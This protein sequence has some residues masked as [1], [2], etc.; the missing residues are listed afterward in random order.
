MGDVSTRLTREQRQLAELLLRQRGL[1]P[2]RLPMS[3]RA[4]PGRAPL[5]TTQQRLWTSG[6]AVRGTAYGN[7]PMAVRIRGSLDIDSLDRALSLIVARHEILRTTYPLED[8]QPI[9]RIGPELPV[10]AAVEDLRA[11][12]SSDRERRFASRVQE[13]ARR[14][15]DPGRETL[16]RAM[17]F[18]L[19]AADWGLLLVSHHLSTDGWGARLLLDELTSAYRAFTDGRRPDLPGLAVQYGDYAAWEAEQVRSGTFESQRLHWLTRLAGAPRQLALPFDRPPAGSVETDAIDISLPDSVVEEVRKLSRLRGVTPYVMLLAGLE[20]MLHQCTGQDDIVIG[21]ILSRRMRS[22]T[23]PL[24][25]NFG[26][27]LLLR[28][29]L[30]G[31]P[32]LMEVVD[33]AAATMRDALAH[34]DVPLE[35]VAQS[36]PIPAFHMMFILRD[37][38]LEERLKL[39]GASVEAVP[40]A[41]GAATLDLIVDITDGERGIHGHLEYR[42]GRFTAGT[43]EQLAA[44]FEDVMTRLVREPNAP[45]GLLPKLLT[46]RSHD[47]AE[48]P[49]SVGEE[50]AT[51]TER[52][53]ARLWCR[54]LELEKAHRQDNFFRLGGDSLRGVYFLEQAEKEIGHRFR[55][56]E[57]SALTLA[58]LAVIRDG[59]TTLGAATVEPRGPTMAVRRVD[60]LRFADQIRSLFQREGMHPLVE[61]FGRAYPEAVKE[62]ASSWV[63]LD[64]SDRIVG[65]IAAFSHRF[66][67]DGSEYR[68]ALGANLVMDSRHR[69]LTNAMAL[70]ERV[71][72]DLGS[73]ENVD[74]LFGDPN[75]GA[76]AIMSSIGGFRDIDLV[77]RFVLPLSHTGLLGP[78]VS[79]YLAATLGRGGREQIDMERRKARDFDT[80]EVERPPGVTPTLRPVHPATLY[81]RRLKDYP[82]E[83]D[84]WYLFTREG[85]RV[86]AVLIRRLQDEGRAQLCCA[87][88][89]PEVPLA[90][91]LRPIVADLRGSR[92]TRLQLCTLLSSPLGREVRAAGFRAR[93]GAIRFG[94]LPCS[95]RGRSLLERG[96]SW[97]ITDLDCDRGLDV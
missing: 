40:A 8:R 85:E 39:P 23:E 3:R 72:A 94:A 77:S 2:A 14:P 43:M 1:D 18:R 79:V 7:V 37:G 65:H 46:G 87:W 71:V 41:S 97:E 38:G 19:D 33:R 15:F 27:N 69:N 76:R 61:F 47:T 64:E 67:C 53:I 55:A 68:A 29:R 86:A 83:G 25:G 28:T 48:R 84:D 96:V 90:D 44:A 45:L 49:L 60:P 73:Q 5:S 70:A 34:S 75:E 50:P 82:S 10:H 63:M 42:T 12:P 81:R 22:E 95:P 56:E 11:V 4:D 58:E 74:F 26:N 35:L 9:Q 80:A 31:D 6:Q 36:A 16:F 78:A 88:R 89:S 91:L 13:E 30:D 59:G 32:A 17:A 57:L 51:R 62:G 93:E 66:V 54:M 92:V 20:I 21:T 52:A 24:I